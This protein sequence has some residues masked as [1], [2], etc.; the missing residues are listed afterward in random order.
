MT[1]A[2][3]VSLSAAR[4]RRSLRSSAGVGANL[5][6]QPD[7]GGAVCPVEDPDLSQDLSGCLL[8]I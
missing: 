8:G 6:G 1:G 5:E 3:R 2:G 4:E 7:C